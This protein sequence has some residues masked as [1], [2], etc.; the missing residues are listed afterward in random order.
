VFSEFRIETQFVHEL[1]VEAF[2]NGNVFMRGA[3]EAM[4]LDHHRNAP[5]EN[6]FTDLD[7]GSPDRLWNSGGDA[8]GGPHAG[9]RETLWNVRHRGHPAPLPGALHFDKSNDLGWPQLNLIGVAG[10]APTTEQDNVWVDPAPGASQ[11]LYEAQTRARI[12]RH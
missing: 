8:A 3:G 9:V 6:L 5:Y 1:S 2:A 12:G 10:Y 4:A 7:V 11:N